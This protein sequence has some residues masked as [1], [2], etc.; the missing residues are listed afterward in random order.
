MADRS[1]TATCGACDRERRCRQ[2][3]DVCPV[4]RNACQLEAL[5]EYADPQVLKMARVAARVEARGYEK[6]PRAQETIEFARD[7]GFRRLGLAFCARLAEEAA[8]YQRRLEREGFAV[9]SVMCKAGAVPKERILGLRDDEKVRPG[10][11]EAMCNPI[12][13][14]RLLADAQ[15]ELNIVVGLCVGHDALFIQHA[16]GPVTVL[17]A[18]DRVYDNKPTDGIFE[19]LTGR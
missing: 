1:W 10:G 17:V 12:A 16:R 6:W 14:A 15:V 2:T 8:A 9:I 4:S 13:Q 18:K 5:E 19:D 11:P 7:M 3:D